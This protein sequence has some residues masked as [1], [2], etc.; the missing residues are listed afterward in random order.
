LYSNVLISNISYD[1]VPR[2]IFFPHLRAIYEPSAAGHHHPEEFDK[3]SLVFS[4]M[5]TGVFFDLGSIVQAED[6]GVYYNLAKTALA[7]ADFL[8][9]P[10]LTCVESLVSMLAPEPSAML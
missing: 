7:A 3:L 2:E 10:T 1:I 4:I 8:N 6:A 5:A 9:K